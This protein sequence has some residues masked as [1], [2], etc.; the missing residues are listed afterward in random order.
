VVR[1]LSWH[2][3]AREIGNVIVIITSTIENRI[4]DQGGGMRGADPFLTTA[5]P[6]SPR[7]ISPRGCAIEPIFPRPEAG[8]EA[9]ALAKETAHEDL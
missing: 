5:V 6:A 2:A 8:L 9:A 1:I 3:K 7:E 4:L